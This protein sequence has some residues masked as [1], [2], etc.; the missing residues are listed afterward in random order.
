MADW[1]LTWE[2]PINEVAGL[3]ERI[4]IIEREPGSCFDRIALREVRGGEVR[5]PYPVLILPGMFSHG[6]QLIHVSWHGIQPTI[7]LT[8]HPDTAIPLYLAKRGFLTYTVDYRTHFVMPDTKDLSFMLKWG[9][10]AWLSDIK[11]VVDKVKELGGKDEVILIGESFG[12]IA[13][14]NFASVDQESIKAIV[15]LDGAPIK[16]QAPRVIS[17]AS[18]SELEAKKLY[19]V[20]SLIGLEFSGGLANQVWL[21]ALYNPSLPSPSPNFRT[22]ADYLVDVLYRAGLANPYSYPYTPKEVAFAVMATF[23]PYWPARLLIEPTD[24]FRV[25]YGNVRVPTLAI[26]SEFGMRIVDMEVLSRIN[27]KI[28][29]LKG[30]GHLDVYVNPNNVKDVNEPVYD[31]LLNLT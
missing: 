26:V 23:D 15:F 1:L 17:A 16:E 4:W 3:T 5:Y 30:Y 21:R 2:G 22:L 18:I 29:A 14:M 9:W 11:V 20:Q 8:Q 6:E 12:G 24:K 10:D 13:S 19:A 25:G 28:I 7:S 27:T 31:W